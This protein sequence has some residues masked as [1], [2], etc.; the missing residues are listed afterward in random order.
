MLVLEGI[1]T[2]YGK[3]RALHGISLELQANSV[4]TILGANGAG[5]STTLMS[6]A[7]LTHPAKGK[8]S[9]LGARIDRRPAEEIVKLGIALVPEGRQI[10]S[11]L[12]VGENLL[13]GSYLRTGKNIIREDLNR[14]CAYFPI[15]RE[16]KNQ[17]AGTLS[18]GEQQML[19]ISRA[20]M[21]KPQLLMLDEPSMGLAPLLVKKIFNIL[22]EIHKE[23]I[24]ILLVEQKASLALAMAHF[25]Y[26]LER[27][28]VSLKG[29]RESFLNSDLVRKSY[30][31][32]SIQRG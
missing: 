12:T 13:M 27:G 3:M 6:I 17:L 22:Q 26:V 24:S 28:K 10:F 31:G 20:L 29:D 1:E 16:R 15:L 4:V 19:A 23:R 18:G 11:K 2:F 32:E 30:L 9:F 21:S 25:G 8:I 5:K 14:V 7:G